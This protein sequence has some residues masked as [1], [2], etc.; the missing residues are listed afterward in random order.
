M[1]AQ[2]KDEN[3]KNESLR[4]EKDDVAR[5]KAELEEKLTELEKALTEKKTVL[6][7]K[8]QQLDGLRQEYETLKQDN[9]NKL[10]ALGEKEE[11]QK[12]LEE[13]I[14]KLEQQNVSHACSSCFLGRLKETIALIIVQERARYRKERPFVQH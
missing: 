10:G 2:I 7:E 3:Q 6:D 12:R 9:Q 13:T 8:G 1:A 5:Q 4:A 11:A 14:A